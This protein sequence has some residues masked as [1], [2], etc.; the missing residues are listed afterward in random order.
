MEIS[1]TGS[2]DN[3]LFILDWLAVCLLIFMFSHNIYCSLFT[4][5]KHVSIGC[6]EH[7]CRLPLW[8]RDRMASSEPRGRVFETQLPRLLAYLLFSPFKVASAAAVYVA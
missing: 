1:T 6:L 4:F 3:G 5:G 2:S 8:L 7:G